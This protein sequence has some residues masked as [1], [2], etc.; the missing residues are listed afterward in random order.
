MSRPDISF[1]VCEA[2]TKFKQVT[3]ADVIY[4]NKIIRNV[5]NFN[6]V[7]KFPQLNLENLK[8]QLFTNASYNNLPNGGS[9][10]GQIIFLTD[11][12]NN[13]CPFYWN[14]SRIKRVVRS[15]IS[16][17]TLSLSEGCDVA[18][19]VD[20][21]ISELLYHDGKL[22]DITAYTDNQ[23]LYDAAH[24]T[25]QT[26]EKRLLVDIAAIREMIERNEINVAW[27]EKNKQISDVLTKAG[28]SPNIIHDV[29]SSSK[30]TEL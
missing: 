7:I 4:V 28:A 20:K 5:K 14:S 29:L 2:S 23:S 22:L 6:H 13:T 21:L 8:L 1:S 15:T 26:L 11:D 19:Y 10:G 27:I 12:K 9:Q 25:K 3:I 17:E 24:S 16:A 30:M 18:I